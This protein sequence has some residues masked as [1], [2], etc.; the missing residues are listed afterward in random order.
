MKAPGK[1][2]S[3]TAVTV[4]VALVAAAAA[5]G[6]RDAPQ[7]SPDRAQTNA[8][9]TAAPVPRSPTSVKVAATADSGTSAAAALLEEAA[10]PPDS[11]PLAT[12]PT[13][14]LRVAPPSFLPYADQFAAHRFLSVPTAPSAVVQFV[15]QHLPVGWSANGPQPVP[16]SGDALVVVGVPGFGPHFQQGAVTYEAV[17]SGSGAALRVDAGVVWNPSRLSSESVPGG[18]AVLVTG[19]ATAS[20]AGLTTGPVTVRVTGKQAKRLRRTFNSLPLAARPDCMESTTAFSLR[21]IPASSAAPTIRAS[22][23]T[24]E[25]GVLNVNAGG[26]GFTTV[27]S[28]CTL[29]RLVASTLP[30]HR[31]RFTHERAAGCEPPT[32]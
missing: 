27:R 14:Q 25:G 1:L 9:T 24:C 7:R 6:V 21:F 32:S 30:R 31:A 18:G 3:W 23:E 8:P 5:L 20:L 13:A 15:L 11:S 29:L 19:Y 2:T 26:K 17:P 28:N 4:V 10:L 16:P 22:E 12:A